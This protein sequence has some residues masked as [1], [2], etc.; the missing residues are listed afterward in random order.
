MTFFSTSPFLGFGNGNLSH[1]NLRFS[2]SSFIN[3]NDH[4]VPK[5]LDIQCLFNFLLLFDVY[6][7]STE[8]WS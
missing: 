3:F 2:V 4:T 7:R 6:E 5:E 1:V 8:G